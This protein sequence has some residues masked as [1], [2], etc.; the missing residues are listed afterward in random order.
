MSTVALVTEELSIGR[1]SGGIGT[2]FHEIAILL[3]GA[4]HEVEVIF[5]PIGGEA[6]E[7]V[8]NYYAAH[9]ILVIRPDLERF[10]WAQSYEHRSYAIFRHLVERDAPYDVIHFHDY[11][12]LGYLSL[13]AKQ[14]GLGFKDTVFIVQVHGPT[15]WALEAND[16]PFSHEDQLKI[17]F[18]ERE[19]IARADV[20]CLPSTYML[21]WLKAKEWKIP[22]ATHVIQNVST[23]HSRLAPRS[24][25]DKRPIPCNEVII[26]GRHEERKGIIQVCDALDLVG[27]KLAERGVTVTMLGGAGKI[28]GEPS[29]IWLARRSS[30]WPFPLRLLPDYDR[31][32]AHEYM[33]ANSRS[34]VVVASP[35]ENSPYTVLEAIVSGKPLIT[36]CNGGAIEMLDPGLRDQLT[37]R[38]DRDG[39]AERITEALEQGLPPARL[40]VSSQDTAQ[41]W[42]DL[43]QA[44]IN[45]PARPPKAPSVPKRQPKVVAGVT[46]FQRPAKLLDAVQSLAAQLYKELEIV[47]V[48][49]GSSDELAIAMLERMAPWFDRLGVRLLRQPNRYLGAARNHIIAKTDSDYLL[50]LDDDDIAFPNLVST[51]VTAAETSGADI[52]SPISL[53]MPEARRTEAHPFPERFEQKVSFVPLGGPLSVAPILNAFGTATCLIRRSALRRSGGYSEVYG[54][55]HEDYELYI[56]AA[57]AGLRIEPC[58]LPLFLYEVD[59]PS[60]VT[61]TSRARNWNRVVKSIDLTRQ[62]TAWADMLS[63]ATGQRC[64]EHIENFGRY[65]EKIDPQSD[66]LARMDAEAQSAAS[67]AEMLGDFA[68]NIG[69]ASFAKAARELAARRL[70]RTDRGAEVILMPPLQRTAPNLCEPKKSNADPLV[71]GGLIDLSLDRVEQAV[72]ALLLSREHG[73]AQLTGAQ[74]RLLR[75]IADH[76]MLTASDAHRLLPPLLHGRFELIDLDTLVPITFR[77]ALRSRQLPI[78]LSALDRAHVI[79]ETLYLANHE[80]VGGLVANGKYASALDHFLR[81]GDRD[82]SGFQQMQALGLA[83]RAEMGANLPIASLRPYLVTLGAGEAPRVTESVRFATPVQ[84]LMP[85]ALRG[86]TSNDESVRNGKREPVKL[87]RR[88]TNG[89]HGSVPVLP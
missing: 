26:F 83:L 75:A 22:D 64:N 3:R 24:T 84:T 45:T 71:L 54:V 42:L 7:E 74:L 33:L 77:L 85:I 69:A 60:M 48:D 72:D 82:P 16:H 4:G 53:Y 30:N 67:Y 43:H 13:V 1:G 18:M 12:G 89:A 52:V 57:Q 49:D 6:E 35:V 19:S 37:C 51:L 56:R 59:R 29:S 21:D 68:Q 73:P 5:V 38:P 50:F 20:L 66:L 55:G 9:G 61:M 34:V 81:S 28:C 88:N 23:Q 8:I 44:L 31:M 86:G 2:A 80:E 46:H 25:A 65:R 14:Q 11:K 79:D 32:Q 70:A 36:S 10:V 76:P 39:L 78:A 27:E 87:S 15:R 62:P 58:P 40:A 63:L 47:V 17:D 41:R